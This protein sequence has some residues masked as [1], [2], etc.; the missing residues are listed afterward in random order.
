VRGFNFGALVSDFAPKF[1]IKTVS[2]VFLTS[3]SYENK[4]LIFQAINVD[5]AVDFLIGTENASKLLAAY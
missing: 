3:K 4:F 5:N 2:A 1:C